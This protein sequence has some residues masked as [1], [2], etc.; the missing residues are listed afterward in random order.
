MTDNASS[1]AELRTTLRQRRNAL[2]Q[3]VREAAAHA[4]AEHA[5]TLPNWIDAARIATYLPA[6]GEIDTAALTLA[7]RVLD[8]QVYLPV[9]QADRSL[10]FAQWQP[11]D[12]LV[13]NRYNIPEPGTN[14]P[15]CAAE[16]LD[17]IFLPVVG[18]DQSGARLGMGGGFYDRTLHNITGPVLAGLAYE[19]QRVTAI[20]TAA[21]DIGLQYVIT[22]AA[23]HR[24]TADATA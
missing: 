5:A 12:R 9:I 14:A 19:I 18:W 1:K 17:I 4:L 7:A 20:P 10:A 8:K 24:P 23:L 13:V 2:T 6:D 11:G 3:A 16:Q 22:E 21:W 15:H